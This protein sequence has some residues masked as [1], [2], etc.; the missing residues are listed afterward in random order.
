ME[1]FKRMNKNSKLKLYTKNQFFYDNDIIDQIECDNTILQMVECDQD[2]IMVEFISKLEEDMTSPASSVQYDID[3][4]NYLDTIINKD[5]FS[6]K[7]SG[8]PIRAVFEAGDEKWL[9]KALNE[10]RNEFIRD[11]LQ[12]IV[13]RGGYGKII[14]K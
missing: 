5:P 10:M 1:N 7:Y 12:Y 9:E 6:A 8:K 13:D 3:F 11:R 14:R 4:Q 2:T